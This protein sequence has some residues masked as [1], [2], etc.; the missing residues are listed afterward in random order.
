M[1]SFHQTVLE[2]V[3]ALS[4]VQ[5]CQ[6]H[7]CTKTATFAVGKTMSAARSMFDI[8][9]TPARKRLIPRAWSLRRRSAGGRLSTGFRAFILLPVTGSFG[10][11]GI[12]P[13]RTRV[14]G[15]AISIPSRWAKAPASTSARRGGTAF[16]IWTHREDSD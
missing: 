12:G 2:S 5:P 11:G 3:V 14:L 10:G 4:E 6:K 9:L 1:P 7:S 16:P 15:A 8:G 13:G